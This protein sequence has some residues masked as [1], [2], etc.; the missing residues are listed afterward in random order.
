MD[1]QD[2][3]HAVFKEYPDVLNVKQ[4]GNLLGVSTKTVYKLIKAD[5]LPCL[6]IGREFRIVKVNLMKY[7]KVLNLEVSICKQDVRELG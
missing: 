5:L 4:V 1:I 6:K 7:M 2:V 3:Y